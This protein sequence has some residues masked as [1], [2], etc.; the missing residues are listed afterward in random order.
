M[1]LVRVTT[2][3]SSD[4]VGG[5][6]HGAAPGM[7]E[8]VALQVK[9]RAQP[10]EGQANAAVEALLAKALKCPK[11]DVSVISGHK[12][13]LKQLLV[14]GDGAALAACFEELMKRT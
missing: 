1:I 12:D 2:K 8:L 5:A 6:W 3:T 11:S 14:K 9:V 7:G 4:V 10:R 13:R